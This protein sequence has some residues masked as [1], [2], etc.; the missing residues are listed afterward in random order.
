MF[1]LKFYTWPSKYLFVMSSFLLGW[2]KYSRYFLATRVTIIIQA[3]A[4][5]GPQD[6]SGQR[7]VFVKFCWNTITLVHL[8]VLPDYLFEW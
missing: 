8:H 2:K 4:H 6:R 5:H 1:F 7:P 3:S